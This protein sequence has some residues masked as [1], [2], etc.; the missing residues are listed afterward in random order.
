M[1]G[2]A[3]AQ[4]TDNGSYCSKTARIQ[5]FL[6][7]IT[8]KYD[9]IDKRIIER[10]MGDVLSSAAGGDRIIIRTIADSHTR[11][12]RLIERCVPYCAAR[13]FFEELVKCSEGSIRADKEFVR[14]DILSAL[15]TKLSTFE[16][17]KYSDIIRT[18]SSVSV[19]DAQ[20]GQRMMLHVYSDL[21]ENS[22]YM[23]G[24]AFFYY[25]V[26]FKIEGLK[27]LKLIAQLKD[28]E[29]DVV[30]VGRAGTADRRPLTVGELAKVTDFWNAYFKESGATK[31]RISQNPVSHSD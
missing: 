27:K 30:G 15:R 29:V 4:T 10:M 21:I 2:T 19:E 14:R 24:A 8:T 23:S 5:V 22:D 11:S 31:V 3:A 6:L 17:L 12:E 26:P 25:S 9:D 28:A 1:T 18:I 13:G 7:D 20:T 16:E